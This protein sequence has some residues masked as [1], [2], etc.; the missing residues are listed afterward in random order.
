M[1]CFVIHMQ[2]FGG[3]WIIE[4]GDF[5]DF[6][7]RVDEKNRPEETEEQRNGRTEERKNRGAEE[8]I[9][10][11]TDEG[12]FVYSPRLNNTLNN[13][14]P[15]SNVEYRRIGIFDC[16][17]VIARQAFAYYVICIFPF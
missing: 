10:R 16:Q 7:E 8:P 4:V 17:V 15:I 13:E 12:F 6:R 5:G 2:F 3:F 9:N 14:Y 11:L 1:V